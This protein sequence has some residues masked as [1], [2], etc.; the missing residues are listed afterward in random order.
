MREVEDSNQ[1]MVD[2]MNQVGEVMETMTQNISIADETVKVMRSKYVETSSNVLSIET[3]VGNL[4][5]DLGT[6]GFMGKEDV[7]V[8]MYLSVR[9]EGARPEKEYKGIISAID[10]S[11]NLQVDELKCERTKFQYDK[12]QKYSVYIIVDNSVYGWDDVKIAHKNDKFSIAVYGNPQV[13]NRRKYPRMPLRNDCD[14]MFGNSNRVYQGKMVN[15][16]AN[17]YAIQTQAK[18]IL[19]MKDNLIKVRVKDFKL[20]EDM[21]LSG[22]VIRITDNAGTYIVGCRMLEDNERICEYVK[23]NYHGN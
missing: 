6:G 12:K 14:I 20:L 21:P 16:S 15:I 9:K 19:D 8:G 3:V 10:E 2:N 23:K 17:G 22:Y 18:E 7:R 4:I 11:G 1:N 5:E 13:V